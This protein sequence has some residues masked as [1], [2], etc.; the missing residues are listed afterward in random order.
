MINTDFPS[1]QLY[2]AREDE[3]KM[4]RTIGRTAG[5]CVIAYVAIQNILPVFLFIPSLGEAYRSNGAFTYLYTIFASVLSILVPFAIGGSYLRKKTGAD[6]APLEAPYG[7]FSALFVAAAGMIVCLIGDYISGW[8]VSLAG[9]AGIDFSSPDFPVPSD[10][11]GRLMF[12]LAVAVVPPLCEEIAVRGTIM[13]PLRRY[14]DVYAIVISSVFF[15]ILHGNLVQAPFAFIAGLA[16][17]Y[18]VCATGSLWTGILIH[19]LN[20]MYSCILAFAAEDLSAQAYNRFYIGSIF[21]LCFAGGVSAVIYAYKCKKL[22]L[23]KHSG[24]LTAGEKGTAFFVNIP[25]IIA[26]VF[27][28]F[29]TAQYISRS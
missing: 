14:G 17:G 27:M 29:I 5:L 9:Y 19:F 25:M 24:M 4:L 28:I 7:G 20:N 21:A 12:V 2:V 22:P 16:F 3:K 8:I 1:A 11:A 13:Q 26:I 18:A 10:A 23:N 15:G 6:T